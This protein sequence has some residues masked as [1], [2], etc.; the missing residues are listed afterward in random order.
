MPLTPYLSSLVHNIDGSSQRLL[1]ELDMKAL[2]ESISELEQDYLYTA[3]N[4]ETIE[5]PY[6]KIYELYEYEVNEHAQRIKISALVHQKKFSEAQYV[7]NDYSFNDN[8]THFKQIELDLEQSG[9]NWFQMKD[10][11]HSLIEAIAMEREVYGWQNAEAVLTLLNS[12]H[13]QEFTMPIATP[14]SSRLANENLVE[15]SSPRRLLEISPNPSS[16]I[17]YLAY[18]LPNSYESAWISV[19]NSLGQ[20]VNQLNI[21]NYRYLYKIDCEQYQS[22]IHLLSLVVDGKVVET[23][24]LSIVKD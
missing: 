13:E 14:T 9:L 2:R 15:N 10:E 20:Q 11:Q 1:L 23:A 16:G 18:E 7:L 21:S 12:D 4:D 3:F 5:N 6:Q 24:K 8:Y 19:Y 17:T 22:G